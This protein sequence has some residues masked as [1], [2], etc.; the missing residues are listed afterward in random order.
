[1]QMEGLGGGAAEFGGGATA[2]VDERTNSI[3]QKC[4]HNMTLVEMQGNENDEHG[5]QDYDNLTLWHKQ[6]IDQ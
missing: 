1:M 2:G 4:W 6:F 3:E 5:H